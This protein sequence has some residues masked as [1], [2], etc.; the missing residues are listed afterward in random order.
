MDTFFFFFKLQT[1]KKKGEK[2]FEVKL[3]IFL[4]EQ[5]LGYDSIT[6]THTHFLG[7]CNF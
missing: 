1:E 5:F 6:L 3:K 2:S 7:Y 4:S